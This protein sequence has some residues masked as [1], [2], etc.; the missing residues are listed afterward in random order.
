MSISAFA[1]TVGLIG[2]PPPAPAGKS[3]AE[4]VAVAAPEGRTMRWHE[5]L[6]QLEGAR[7]IY[8]GEKHDELAHHELQGRLIAELGALDPGLVVG[9]EMATADDQE[10]LDAYVS[11]AMGEAEFAAWWKK[12]WGFDFALYRPAL[13]AARAAKLRIRGLNAPRELVRAVS[14]RGLAGLTAEERARLPASI[15]PSADARYRKFVLDSLNDHGPIPPERLA[16]MLEAM[17]VWN[18]TMGEN[19]AK[20]ARDARVIVLA[21]SGHVVWKAGVPES[22][23]RRGADA[24]L[25]ALPFPLDGERLDAAEALRRLRDPQAGELAKADRFVLFP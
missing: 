15:E 2:A 14:R 21:G 20:L 3:A 24:G 25:V 7:L 4:L 17:A 10:T 6:S 8:V 5:L 12:S 22:A 11:G 1:L 13:E 9:L 18:E 23:A 19:A 16:R